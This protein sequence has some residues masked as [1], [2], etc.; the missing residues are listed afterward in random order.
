VA[1]LDDRYWCHPKIVS[2]S[3]GAYRANT[4]AIAYCA[5]MGTG[6]VLDQAQQRVVGAQAKHR[7]ELVAGGVWDDLGGGRIQIHDWDDHNSSRD[8]RRES[9]RERKRRQR[10]RDREPSVTAEVTQDVTRDIAVTDTVTEAVTSRRPAR[11]EGSEGSERTSSALDLQRSTS[12]ESTESHNEPDL[13]PALRK[14]ALAT[15]ARTRDDIQK[16]TRAA[17]SH[18]SSESDIQHAIDACTGPGVQSRLAVALAE[19]VKRSRKAA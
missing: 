8:R 15:G 9:D 13:S 4:N 10:Q 3:D 16:L 6:G 7:R 18:R 12:Y 11:V 2:L 19:L 17:R 5:G 14:L 1:W